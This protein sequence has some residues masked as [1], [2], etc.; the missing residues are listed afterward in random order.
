MHFSLIL[1][2]AHDGSKTAA[3]VAEACQ[4]GKVLLVEPVPWL[5][6]KL[7]ARHGA[8][9]D[10]V[11]HNA[12]VS[13]SE[14]YVDFYAPM[15][16]AHAALAAAHA[17]GAYL[18]QLGSLNA[19]HALQHDLNFEGKVEKI[20]VPA[21]TFGSLFTKYDVTS[22]QCLLT[23]T[24]GYDAVILSN[25]PFDRIKPPKI[26]FEHKHCDGAKRIGS[27]FARLLIMLEGLG[28]GMQIQDRENCLAQLDETA[29]QPDRLGA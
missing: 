9:P 20:V 8:N 29:V 5:F 2:G 12:V 7:K 22:V 24:E 17:P 21:D 26:I 4:D 6:E 11:L 10:I 1:V 16:A 13:D 27:K 15:A 14:G 25:F 18:D 28:Y 19:R 23:D 3:M